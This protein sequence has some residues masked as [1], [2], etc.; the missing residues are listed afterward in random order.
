M[1]SDAK[2][3]LDEPLLSKKHEAISSVSRIFKVRDEQLTELFKEENR[4]AEGGASN[5]LQKL[6]SLG[7]AEGVM[8]GLATDVGT[9]IIGDERD[10]RRRS[11][12]F[13]KN[14]K[15]LPALPSVFG[16]IKE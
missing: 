12:L 4:A 9:G 5:S 10:I 3:G 7:F 11:G 8:Q 6:K 1:S 13:G 14:T 2:Q 16:S 15:P